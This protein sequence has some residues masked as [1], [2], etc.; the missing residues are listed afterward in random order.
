LTTNAKGL[1]LEK[2]AEMSNGL[3]AFANDGV[4]RHS[5]NVRNS[6]PMIHES[7]IDDESLSS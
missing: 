6:L 1:L 2:Q 5:L 7:I 4:N 3:E